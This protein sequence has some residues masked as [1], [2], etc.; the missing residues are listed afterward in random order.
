MVQESFRL[1]YAKTAITQ[2]VKKVVES[3]T[4]DVLTHCELCGK[5]FLKMNSNAHVLTHKSKN[6]VCQQCECVLTH[7]LS[8]KRTRKKIL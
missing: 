4:D 1:I 5:I 8:L 2:P 3:L 7:N 6:V